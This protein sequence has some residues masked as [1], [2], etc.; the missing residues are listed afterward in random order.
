MR[1]LAVVVFLLAASCACVPRGAGSP[2]QTALTVSAASSLTEAFTEIGAAFTRENPGA[3]VT[4]NFAASGVLVG[5]I[6]NG[7]PVDVFAAAASGELDAV[8]QEGRVADSSRV[9]FA[10]N[11]LVLVVPPPSTV[12]GWRDLTAKGVKHVAIGNPETVPAGRYA[13]ETLQHRNLWIA[14]ENK[15]VLGENVRQTLTYVENGDADAGVVFITDALKAG[16]KVRVVTKANAGID[17]APIVYPAAVIRGARHEPVARRF[18]AFL[19]SPEAQAI[20][21]KHGFASLTPP[22]TPKAKTKPAGSPAPFAAPV[23]R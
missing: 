4:F 22:A 19:K 20:L 23:N 7:A 9:E 8:A 11:R 13:R 14:V 12:A 3:P 17:H 16:K 21:K 15:L 18:V 5:Q 6:K 2:R 10:G 1:Y